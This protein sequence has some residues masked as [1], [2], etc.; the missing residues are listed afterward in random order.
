[1]AAGERVA[2]G[3][4]MAK[5]RFGMHGAV[6]IVSGYEVGR[7]GFW[8]HRSLVHGGVAHGVGD[9]SSIEVSRRAR[10]VKTDRVD[11][12]QLLR[13]LIR[14]QNGEK[15]VWSV[16]HGPRTGRRCPTVAP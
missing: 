8:L 10:R 9:A 12:E 13:L 7:E 15:R 16:P 5:A 11:V 14:Y 4:A 1:M 2:L 3:E 6:S